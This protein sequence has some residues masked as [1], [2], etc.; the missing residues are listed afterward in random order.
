MGWDNDHWNQMNGFHDGYGSHGVV[1]G[2]VILLFVGFAIWAVIR[3]SRSSH[4]PVG[5]AVAPHKETPKEILDRRF[6]S[7]EISAD[8]YQRAKELLN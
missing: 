4:K 6:A 1:M 3:I 8:E 5:Q 7:G 2:L